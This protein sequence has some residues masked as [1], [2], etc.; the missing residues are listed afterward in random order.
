MARTPLADKYKDLESIIGKYINDN[1]TV[2]SA[3]AI[4]RLILDKENIQYH[5]EHLS[6]RIRKYKLDHDIAEKI[7]KS[8][9]G[10]DAGGERYS[11]SDD[12]YHW[13]TKKLGKVV[14]P[15]ELADRLF[16]EFSRHG[17]NMSQI[18][19]R[20][21][22]NISI[23]EWHSIKSVLWLYKDSNIFSP[24]TVNST[25]D[26]DLQDMIQKKMEMKFNDKNRLVEVEYDKALQKQYKKV[27]KDE[28]V[29]TFALEKMIDE[30]YD[31][32]ASNSSIRSI[33]VRSSEGPH[34]IGD[35][36]VPLADLH[37]G[38]RVE[39]LRLTPE[40]DTA[41]L[42][43][44]LDDVAKKINEKNAARVHIQFLGD[45]IESF[46]GLNHINSWQS[47]EYGVYGAK[48]V[49]LALELIEEFI[50]KVNNVFSVVGISGNH[51]R[52][53]SN[54]KE[55]VRGQVAEIIF[56]MLKR[57]YGSKFE[58]D[59]DTLVLSKRID[60]IN[61]ILAHGDKNVIKQD[62]KQAII[63]YGDSTI[64]NLILSGHLH[65]RMIKEDQKTYR[66]ILC[67]SIFTGNF[68]SE[69]NGWLTT[70]GVLLIYNNGQGLP[71]IED[72]SLK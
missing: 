38:A 20:Q 12:A 33:T 23:Q 9:Y 63:D 6:Y 32:T 45:L 7:T 67:P 29:K 8:T 17:L 25:P 56:Y 30:L 71:I 57:L 60:G 15:V 51:D 44:R 42:R 37:I 34:P 2:K 26:Q 68:Y 62:G 41:V 19:I 5:P 49:I 35:L 13:E 58:M 18:A 47:I 52:I 36:I 55:D 69:S 53:S 11:V 14:I 65:T 24:H 64:Y 59:Y 72:V 40:F 39:G 43:R 10:D 4:A 50:S 48:V 31:L 28:S 61:Y 22:H 27:I 1:P 3:A 46:T 54:N 70:A 16:Y 21:K 66:W